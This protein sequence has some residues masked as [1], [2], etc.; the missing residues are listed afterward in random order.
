MSAVN[1]VPGCAGPCR[2]RD[3]VDAL[4]QRHPADAGHRKHIAREAREAAVVVAEDPVARDAR[5]DDPDSGSRCAALQPRG[6]H[7]RPHPDRVWCGLVTI[8]DRVTERHEH[9]G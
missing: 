2:V 9:P 8:G 7:R 6:E 5:V 3:V 1:V 4:E